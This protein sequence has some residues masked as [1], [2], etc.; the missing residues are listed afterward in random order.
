[1]LIK[2][3]VYLTIDI[4]HIIKSKNKTLLFI[5]EIYRIR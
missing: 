3:I 1:M 5:E 4:N 2:K